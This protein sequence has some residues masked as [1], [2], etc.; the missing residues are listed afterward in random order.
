MEIKEHSF[1]DADDDDYPSRQFVENEDED[2]KISESQN[3]I[4]LGQTVSGIDNIF[5]SE[6]NH[7]PFTSNTRLS[8]AE[9]ELK[10]HSSDLVPQY[11]END[12]EM[13]RKEMN[14]HKQVSWPEM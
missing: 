6:L 14:F 2:E 12:E 7:T 11:F 10:K 9:M 4:T 8:N 3:Q 5:N 1:Y 13:P